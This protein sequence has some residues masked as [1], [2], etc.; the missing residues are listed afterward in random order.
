[1]NL[2]T[3]DL[4]VLAFMGMMT[5]IAGN[6]IVHRIFEDDPAPQP[7]I[8]TEPTVRTIPLA[9]VPSTTASTTTT[10]SE[11]PK[12]AHDA[13]QADLSTLTALDTPCQ[14]WAQLALEVGWPQEELVNVLEE[15]WQESRCLNIIPGDPRW[16]GGDHGLLQINEVW[17]NETAN[18]FGSWDRI[19][20]PAV[21]LAMALEIWRWHDAHRGCGWEP[22]SRPC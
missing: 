2:R 1:M 13:L 18:L 9:P 7:A 20:E 22:W 17:A 14:E 12:T 10:T 6:E 15:M 8:V 3:T 21:N 4:I 19:N 16:N 5:L 11:A